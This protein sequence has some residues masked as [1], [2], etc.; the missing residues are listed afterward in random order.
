VDEH[1][2]T[3]V[4]SLLM[5]CANISQERHIPYRIQHGLLWNKNTQSGETA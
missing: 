3:D 4:C 1:D 5:L 2:L